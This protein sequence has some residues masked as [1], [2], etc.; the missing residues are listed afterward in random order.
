MADN[1]NNYALIVNAEDVTDEVLG[2]ARELVD[3]WYDDTRI[4]WEDVW[5]RM[6]RTTLD[7]GRKIDM[8]PSTDSAAMKAI[9]RQIN[10]ERREG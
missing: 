8:G 3:G 7:D 9:K 2:I 10:K 4:D 1:D 5:D 6:D